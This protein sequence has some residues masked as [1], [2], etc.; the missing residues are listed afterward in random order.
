VR[1]RPIVGP[2]INVA[3]FVFLLEETDFFD[4]PIIHLNIGE[5]SWHGVRLNS[6][7]FMNEHPHRVFEF[8]YIEG[9]TMGSQVKQRLGPL[10]SPNGSFSAS[11][12]AVRSPAVY[13]FTKHYYGVFIIR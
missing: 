6:L 7:S 10:D 3:T 12:S 11:P 13:C 9:G 4:E 1:K 2:E 8:A 5:E